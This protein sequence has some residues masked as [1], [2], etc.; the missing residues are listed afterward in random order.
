MSDAAKSKAA[1]DLGRL[2]EWDL[3]DLYGGPDAP[4]IEQDLA[5]A[6]ERAGRLRKNCAGRLAALSGAELGTALADYEA[7][8]EILSKLMSYAQLV[9]AGDMSDPRNGRF[10]QRIHEAV[11][12]IAAELIFF[13]LE[14]NEIEDQA[15]EQ[16]LKDPLLA[17]YRPWIR[18]SRAFRPYQLEEK[19]ERLLHDKQVAGS[20]AWTR[21]FDETMAGLRFRLDGEELTSMQVLNRMSEPDRALRQRA[22]EAFAAGLRQRLPLFS[23]VT[24]TLAK[25]KQIED[26]WRGLPRPVSSRNLANRVEDEVVD[27]LVGA[28]VESYPQLSHRYYALKAKWLGLEK[29]SYWDR[30]APLPTSDER[31]VPWEEAQRTV[32]TAY[33]DFSEDLAAVGRRFFERPW[34]DA[35]ARPGKQSGAF[36]HPT[37]PSA[38]PYLLLNYQ[39]KLRDVM[40]LAHELGH[41]C[42]QV[43]AGGQGHLLAGTPLTLAETASVFGEMLTFRRLLKQTSE[44]ARRKAMLAGK[45]EDMLNTVVRQIAFHR[46]ETQV[47]DRRHEGELL[48]DELAE[49]W[50]ATQTEALG[51][52]FGFNEDYRVYWAYIPHF[53]HSPFYVYA[54]AFGDCL[55]NSLYAVYQEAEAGFAEKYLD[56][57]RAGGSKRHRELLAPFGLDASDPAF[58]KKGL[59]VVSGLIDELEQLD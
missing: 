59:S 34:I 28:V 35:P 7:I 4:A 5:T 22:G 30:N 21:L 32:L 58:W 44:P 42:H 41:G 15:L 55:V 48:S 38:H 20:A 6:R 23:L 50:M 25:D 43:L 39:G 46:F 12:T 16:K 13:T 57:L 3:A 45:V 26:S 33:A 29:L 56:M 47:H 9:Y 49:I 36:A 17:R 52:A 19:L 54:Y 10:Y 8:D 2:P 14:L 1:D 18:D 27:A 53:V 11:S 31:E 51:P 37:V 24:N 40:T